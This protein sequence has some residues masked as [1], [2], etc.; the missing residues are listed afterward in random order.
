MEGAFD[1]NDADGLRALQAIRKRVS[2]CATAQEAK[3]ET[4]QETKQEVKRD[5]KRSFFFAFK[6]TI[7]CNPLKKNHVMKNFSC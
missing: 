1:T 7:F 5:A 2:H 4:K 3:Q 6:K